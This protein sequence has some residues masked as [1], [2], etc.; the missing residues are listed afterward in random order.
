M[1]WQYVNCWPCYTFLRVINKCKHEFYTKVFL[2]LT[3]WL[4][5]RCLNGP[6]VGYF[7][8]ALPNRCV[9]HKINLRRPGPSRA[10][11]FFCYIAQQTYI[12]D[13]AKALAAEEA[14]KEEE[15]D[16]EAIAEEGEESEEEEEEEEDLT[17]EYEELLETLKEN[18]EQNNGRL[19]DQYVIK[20]FR[21]KLHSKP[22]QN[23]GF[24]IDGFPK[25][26]E[27]AKELFAG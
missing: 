27:Q 4:Q 23:Q 10:K 17:G 3:R 26:L 8:N 21:E 2:L 7:L 15:L 19:E 25:T 9:L 6:S 11:T 14:K 18:R 12:D 5:L 1:L 24:I 20:F 16:E 13:K 22:C